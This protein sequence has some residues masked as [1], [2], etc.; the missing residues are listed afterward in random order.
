[1][2]LSNSA[3]ELAEAR[4]Q[5]ERQA[6]IESASKAVA[7][8]GLCICQDCGLMIGEARQKAA[9]FA[10]RCINCQTAFEHERLSR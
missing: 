3:Y 9:P 6:A 10:R 8:T 4:T 5:Q 7:K 1:M 2:N